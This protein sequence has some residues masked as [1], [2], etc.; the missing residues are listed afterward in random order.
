MYDRGLTIRELAV[1]SGVSTTTIVKMLKENGVNAVHKSNARK[2]A[3]ALGLSPKEIGADFS[4]ILPAKQ[5]TLF[6]QTDEKPESPSP[7]QE[8]PAP[9]AH[10]VDVMRWKDLAYRTQAGRT[11]VPDGL[12]GVVC[13]VRIGSDAMAPTLC[14]GDLAYLGDWTGEEPSG[15]VAVG[16]QFAEGT[17]IG[18]V[19]RHGD[20][21]WLKPENG[22]VSMP[23][24]SAPVEHVIAVVLAA[25]VRMRAHL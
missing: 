15:T 1:L 9:K 18:R 14:A 13:A 12:E 16:L 20:Q 21:I 7:H 4:D 22:A 8:N 19:V 5:K 24:S 11:P 17:V 6:F 23:G 2:V 25:T 10:F 3:T